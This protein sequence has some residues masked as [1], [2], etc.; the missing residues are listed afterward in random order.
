MK[1]SLFVILMLLCSMLAAHAQ[2]VIVKKDGST[3]VCR[4]LETSNTHV[5]YQAWADPYGPTQM[6]KISEVAN[7]NYE[8]GKKDKVQEVEENIYAPN[9]QNSG[10]GKYNDNALLD[11]QNQMKERDRAMAE[12]DRQLAH[13]ASLPKKAKMWK[14]IGYV[15]GAAL[16]AGGIVC[17]IGQKR[18]HIDDDG[19][20]FHTSGFLGRAWAKGEYIE[21]KNENGNVIESYYK[22]NETIIENKLGYYLGAGL[23]GGG[24]IVGGLGYF[25]SQ[26]YQKE[27]QRYSLFENQ[28]MFNNGTSLNASID[29]IKD[30]RLKTNTFGIGIRYNF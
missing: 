3:I 14:Y 30:T 17:L 20:K 4:V 12:R 21:I 26:K 6:V 25:M 19:R 13:I 18:A 16:V 9:N 23:I 22:Y 11:M 29:L 15:G 10:A 28:F 27:L 1:K 7:I 5:F 8:K 2:D 24:V